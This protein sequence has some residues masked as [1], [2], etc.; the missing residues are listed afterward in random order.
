MAE[1]V[2]RLRVGFGDDLGEDLAGFILTVTRD[3]EGVDAD[4]HAVTIRRGL[5]SD[6]VDLLLD[7]LDSVAVGKI[8]IG[9]AG[10][11]V[12]R[13]ARTAALEY[14]RQ[15]RDRLRFQG[16]VVEAIEVAAEIE[17]VL[18]P[19]AAK[20][21]YELLGS[22]VSLVVVEPIEADR[23]ELAAEPS[24]HDIHRNSAI[25]ELTDRRDLFGDDG[26]MPGTRQDRGDHVD[27]L[28]RSN[29]RVTDGD[30]TRAGIPRHIRR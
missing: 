2:D 7:S 28:R 29:Q 24:A 18:A 10:R 12:A 23:L 4:L 6:V 22:S 5:F 8:P 14:L 13:S 9:Y 3:R 16:V 25:V 15:R 30:R 11:H 20:R 21:A 1:S 27:A 17:V 26:G 19:N